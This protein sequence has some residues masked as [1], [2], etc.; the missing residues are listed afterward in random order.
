MTIIVAGQKFTIT[1]QLK[2][3]IDNKVQTRFAP[4]AS[5]I[6][7][8]NITVAHEHVT[9]K[10]DCAITSDFGEFHSTGQ[11]NEP[12]ASVDKAVD[13]MVTEIRKK[14]DKIIDKR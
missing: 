1:P 9:F 2:E 6:H 14:H 5:R 11:F 13:I 4:Y 10:A 3:F 7:K 12:E 8:V